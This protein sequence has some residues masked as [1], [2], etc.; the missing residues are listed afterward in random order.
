[1][2]EVAQKRASPLGNDK[3]MKPNMS[4]IIHS[5][6]LLCACCLESVAAG[7]TIFC[8]THIVA[9]TIIAR[10]VSGVARLNHRKLFSKG[11]IEYTIGQEE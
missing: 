6:I 9:A 5:I 2:V 4:G 8:C 1:M 7:V 10:T 3:E 11:T